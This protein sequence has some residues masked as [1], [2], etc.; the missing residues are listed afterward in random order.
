VSHI[1]KKAVV[2]FDLGDGESALAH[3]GAEGNGDPDVLVVIDGRQSFVTCVGRG[4]DGALLVGERALETDGARGVRISFKRRSLDRNANSGS[5]IPEFFR[6]VIR[7]ASGV[8]PDQT[9]IVVGHP[10]AWPAADVAD[11][12]SSLALSELSV[13][14]TPE[15]RAAFLQLKESSFITVA[16]LREA[17]LIIDIGSSTTDFTLVTN[18]RQQPVDFGHNRLGASL[19]ERS[20][21]ALQL[22]R[23][24]DGT[25]LKG[26]IEANTTYSARCEFAC[27]KQKEAFF[28]D[29]ENYRKSGDVI[30][31]P[32]VDLDHEIFFSPRGDFRDIDAALNLPQPDLDGRGWRDAYHSQLMVV[33]DQC[34]ASGVTPKTVALTGGASRMAFTREVALKVFPE[35][36]IVVDVAPEFTI[37]KGLARAGRWELRSARFIGELP[38][39]M[40]AISS[41]LQLESDKMV[42]EV[43]PAM[44]TSFVE[45]VLD[46]SLRRWRS[47]SVVRLNG[48][49]A[50]VASGTEAWAKSKAVADIIEQSCCKWI[51]ATM[52]RAMP[53][54]QDLC[55]RYGVPLSSVIR[56]VRPQ[57]PRTIEADVDGETTRTIGPLSSV[58]GVFAGIIAAKIA[59]V[60]TPIILGVLVKTGVIVAAAAGPIGWV[61]AAIAGLASAFGFK[62]VVERTVRDSD[63][64]RPVRKLMLSDAK[65][66]QI[67]RDSVG[68]VEQ[69]L[70][71]EIKKM[72]AGILSTEVLAML[73]ADLELQMQNAMILLR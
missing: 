38:P 9:D 23:H 45:T 61:I 57:G 70:R 69:N 33:R 65:I 19:I 15:S 30:R 18:L 17:A 26:A 43:T 4:R 10:S 37:A 25:R 50:D 55:S 22:Q 56:P 36:K 1:H 60:V 3:C 7:Q 12:I 67:C 20:L 28:K 49:S 44:S 64:P 11:Y 32:A 24:P 72:T 35:A 16:E 63:I 66:I 21:L 48:I 41:A 51:E 8:N 58:A 68:N 47:G 39:I 14:A 52:L 29:E 54:L 71:P 46:G 59:L 31:G 6:E 5:L 42:N 27:R 62:Q 53:Q 34:S 13:R 73:R 40:E 2:G